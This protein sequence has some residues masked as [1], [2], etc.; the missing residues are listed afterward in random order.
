M[1]DATLVRCRPGYNM[2]NPQTNFTGPQNI[3]CTQEGWR[4]ITSDGIITLPPE[5]KRQSHTHT[6]THQH[7]LYHTIPYHTHA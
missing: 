7:T 5:C 1:L 2:V 4:G 6:R 3:T